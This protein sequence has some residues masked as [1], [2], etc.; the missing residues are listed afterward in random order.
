MKVLSRDLSLW[1]RMGEKRADEQGGGG[2][3]DR[4]YWSKRRRKNTGVRM[5]V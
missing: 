5:E 1:R 3:I 4:M 2:E